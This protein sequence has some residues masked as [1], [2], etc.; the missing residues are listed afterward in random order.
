MAEC[1]LKIYIETNSC[2]NYSF[3][4]NSISAQ[5]PNILK[6]VQDSADAAM[7]QVEKRSDER[8]KLALTVVRLKQ[9]QDDLTFPGQQN[10]K[11]YHRPYSG[12]PAPK[13]VASLR[14]VVEAEGVGCNQSE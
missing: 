2:R 5:Y 3:I 8:W 4:G 13:V 1:I 10:R 9:E 11:I 14:L 12:T 7:L 6:L